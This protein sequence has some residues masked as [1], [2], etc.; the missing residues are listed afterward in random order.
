MPNG[1]FLEDSETFINTQGL[2]KRTTKLIDFKKEAKNNWQITRK[3]HTESRK[4]AV[5]NHQKDNKLIVFNNTSLFNYKSYVN[6]TL[7]VARTLNS[8]GFYLNTQNEPINKTLNTSIKATKVRLFDTK[9]K[10]WLDDFFSGEKD[11]FT[12]NSTVLADCSKTLR[13]NSTNFF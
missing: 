5:F 3:F 13:V 9:L 1:L 10:A 8:L 7:Y 6:L 12:R 11:F 4:L 2:I